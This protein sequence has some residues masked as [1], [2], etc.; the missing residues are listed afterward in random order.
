MDHFITESDKKK[1]VFACI[2]NKTITLLE[3]I[4]KTKD[5]PENAFFN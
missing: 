3:T 1:Y 5:D 2:T 4:L